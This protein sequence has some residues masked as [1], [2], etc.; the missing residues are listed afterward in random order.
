MPDAADNL[1][2]RIYKKKEGERTM[3]AF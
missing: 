3:D 1:K 2:T